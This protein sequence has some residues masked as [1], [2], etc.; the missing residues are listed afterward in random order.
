MD[1]LF[2]YIFS[3]IRIS[4]LSSL[5]CKFLIDAEAGI[6]GV[7]YGMLG[8]NLPTPDKVILLLQSRNIT[9]IRLFDPNPDALKALDGSGI[10]VVLGTLNDDLQRLG[11]DPLFAKNWIKINVVPHAKTIHFRCITAGNEVVP[12]E[13]AVHVLPAMKNLQMALKAINLTIPVSTAVSTA[14]L[15][16]SFPPSQGAFSTEVSSVMRSITAFLA[17]NKSP[18]LVNIY[19]YFAYIYDQNNILLDYAL[20]NTTKVVVRDGTL[21]YKNLFDAIIDA[22]Y[23][24]LEKVGGASV[25]IVISESGWPSAEN[26]DIATIRNARMYNNNLIAHALGN[27]GSPKRPGKCLETYVFAIFNEDLKPPG[28]EQNFGLFYP[29]MTEVYHVSFYP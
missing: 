28:T 19:P 10:D 13:L 12:S 20:F 25:D 2:G 11:S 5:C 15:G 1:W 6:V 7:N 4:L 27:S 24:A 22:T 14:V 21:G 9:R 8:D 23:S 26:G 16:T 17:A 3:V 29:N 18:L